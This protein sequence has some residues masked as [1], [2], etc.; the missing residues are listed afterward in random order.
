MNGIIK[1]IEDLESKI[2]HVKHLVENDKPKEDI[3]N[4]LA[5]PPEPE[6]VKIVLTKSEFYK[7]VR[8]CVV[9]DATKRNLLFDSP[10]GTSKT[11]YNLLDF[12]GWKELTGKLWERCAK[13]K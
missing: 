5:P 7:C 2:A 8:D 3:L 12:K 1:K 11:P 6:E 9:E 10:F 13:I 4:A